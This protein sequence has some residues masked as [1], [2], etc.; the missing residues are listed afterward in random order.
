M[1]KLF[2]YFFRLFHHL[3]HS[4]TKKV[5]KWNGFF[6]E[7]GEQ[8]EEEDDRDGLMIKHGLHPLQDSKPY[9]KTLNPKTLEASENWNKRFQ[10]KKM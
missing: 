8:E 7:R 3:L 1:G 4:S 10:E 9:R 2:I 5:K 6:V